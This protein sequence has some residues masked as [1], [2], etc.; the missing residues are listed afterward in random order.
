MQE[1]TLLTISNVTKQFPGVKALGDVSINIKRGEIHGLCGEN[2]AG[3]STLMKILCGVYPYG[4]YEGKVIYD[5]QE[6]KL[7]T[8]SIMQAIKEGI[9]I[10]YQEL[11]LIP[12]MTVGE[13]IFLGKEPM[14]GPVVDWNKLYADTASLLKKYKLNV[15]PYD[16]VEDLGIGQMQMTEIAKALSENAR[17][18]I[19]DE[20]TSALSEA[21]VNKLMEI[22]TELKSQGVTCIYISHKLDEFFRI[23]DT[24]TV[25]RDGCVVTTQPTKDLSIDQLVSL[26]VGREMTERFPKGNRKPAEVFLEVKDL[27]ATDPDNP[28]KKVLKGVN[29]SLKKGEILGIAGLMGSGRTELVSTIFGEYAHVVKGKIFVD[30]KEEKINSAREAMELGISLVPE[31][32]KRLGLVLMQ[33]ILQNISLPNLDRFSKFMYINKNAE[34]TETIKYSKSLSIKAPSVH[35]AVESLSG[36]NQQKVVISKWLM[37]EP[38]IFILDDPTRGI[39]VGAKYEIYKLMN[40]L[41]ESGFAIIMISS[42]LEEVLGMSDRVMV[43]WNGRSNGTLDIAD[44]TEEKIMARATGVEVVEE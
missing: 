22:L 21:E 16:L 7:G 5:G 44:A 30:G 4:T 42:E 10:V 33:T 34:L 8:S 31:D 6:L 37:S 23:T 28:S 39:D 40:Q 13:N 43:M 9:A 20:P 15:S 12:K 26:M 2:G 18:L 17:V 36:G 25:L 14:R 1:D 38:R 29:L 3:K 27:H 24:V 19:L 32:R 41:A 35:V 11:T